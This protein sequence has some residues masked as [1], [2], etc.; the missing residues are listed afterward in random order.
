M[1]NTELLYE[2]P[3]SV[4]PRA[5]I[6]NSSVLLIKIDRGNLN[7]VIKLPQFLP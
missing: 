7:K 4:T 2:I 5:D 1:E 3:P 6:I